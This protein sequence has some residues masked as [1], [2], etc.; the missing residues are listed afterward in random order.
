M[1]HK[2]VTKRQISTDRIHNN[3][4]VAKF[5]NKL[6]KDGKKTTAEKVLYEAFDLMEK[7]GQNALETF[8]KAIQNVGPRQE[9]KAKR[10]GGANY[11]VPMEVRGERR[12]SLSVRWIIEAARARSNKDYKSFA[13]K[14]A[15]ELKDA[16]EN[17]GAAVKKRDTAHRMAEANRAFS[18]FRF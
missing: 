14:L 9:V 17:Q 15:A 5:I 2:K 3:L 1:R 11:Q 7:N 13:A 4:M 16:V 6:M 18:H 8:E 10:V 12:I